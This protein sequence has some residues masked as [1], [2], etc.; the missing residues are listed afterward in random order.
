MQQ[1]GVC[2]SFTQELKTS[3]KVNILSFSCMMF[4]RY[5]RIAV[6]VVKT[7]EFAHSAKGVSLCTLNLE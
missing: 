4:E 5:E 7:G 6:I 2:L 1:I 3:S